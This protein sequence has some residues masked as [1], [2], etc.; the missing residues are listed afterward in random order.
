LG[1]KETIV[2]AGGGLEPVIL[3]VD[4]DRAATTFS[5][6]SGVGFVE[7]VPGS[8]SNVVKVRDFHA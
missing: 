3:T 6:S 2:D 1:G 7:L 4:T 8:G 5:C